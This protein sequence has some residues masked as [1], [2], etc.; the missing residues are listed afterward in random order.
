MREG[1]SS[2]ASMW[3][4]WKHLFPPPLSTS[5]LHTFMMATFHPVHQP[6]TMPRCDCLPLNTSDTVEALLMRLCLSAD[7]HYR[8][9]SLKKYH[10]LCFV[11]KTPTLTSPFICRRHNHI[12]GHNHKAN[13][14]S[15]LCPKATDSFMGW[16]CLCTTNGFVYY[17]LWLSFSD[18]RNISSQ[19][20]CGYNWK[21]A[22]GLGLFKA[23]S[24]CNERL[25]MNAW[26]KKTT[27]IKGNIKKTHQ[28]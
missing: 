28:E 21:M 12:S 25:K 8:E 26:K 7:I 11:V 16:F 27:T 2:I 15:V 24:D 23:N 13:N 14:S 22:W 1:Q 5:T 4:L 20:F 17:V 6:P 18:G 3:R 19:Y 10:F 9:Q